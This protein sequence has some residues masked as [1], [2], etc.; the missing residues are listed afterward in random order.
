MDC[1]NWKDSSDARS[2]NSSTST[3]EDNVQ[4]VEGIVMKG[5]VSIQRRFPT[6]SKQKAN[7]CPIFHLGSDRK[8]SYHVELSPTVQQLQGKTSDTLYRSVAVY[9]SFSFG[10]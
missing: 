9:T 6:F 7:H 8:W 1:L 3:N 2:G 4:V 5:R 10:S